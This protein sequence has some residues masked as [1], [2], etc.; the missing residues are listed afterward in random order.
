MR[1]MSNRAR[2]GLIVLIG[3]VALFFVFIIGS[4]YF[5]KYNVER[6]LDS[7]CVE[8]VREAG[9]LLMSSY[10]LLLQ[11]AAYTNRVSGTEYVLLRRGTALYDEM[12]SPT[13][14]SLRPQ[15]V[16]VHTNR[17]VIVLS[18]VQNKGIYVLGESAPMYGNQELGE[19]VW[20]AE[21]R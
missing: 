5:I 4:S 1:V 6:R 7:L 15:R 3:L 14:K 19:R 13:I 18:V 8:G 2:L 16:V 17:V 12:C 21:G 20:Y 10:E 11:S 9:D